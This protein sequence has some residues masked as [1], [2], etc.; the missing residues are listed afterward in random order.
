[1]SFNTTIR[2]AGPNGTVGEQAQEIGDVVNRIR[3][4]G[5]TRLH[6][7]VCQALGQADSVQVADESAGERRLYA[8]VLLSDGKD[9]AS[10]RSES[11][12]FNC[13]P[14]GETA[15]GIKIFTIAYGDNADE[16]LLER[17][18]ARTNG[19]FYTGDPENIQEVYRSISFE[20]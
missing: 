4:S 13:L 3:A 9:T 11:Q 2:Q 20:Q 16:E 1:M 12:M 14:S 15:E 18:A 10:T 8:I 7:A 5:D 17:I 19:R 6:D